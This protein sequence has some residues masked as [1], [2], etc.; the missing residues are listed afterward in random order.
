MAAPAARFAVL[1]AA[2]LLACHRP[3]GARWTSCHC[4]YVT[5][6][7]QPGRV[8][9]EICAPA[10]DAPAVAGGCARDRGVGAVTE[11]ACD[12]ARGA[13][14]PCSPNEAVCRDPGAAP[15]ARK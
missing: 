1:F 6:F 5:D 12:A 14:A 3:S 9:V 15:P 13:P 4:A 2:A 8:D 10:E 11:C 7:D